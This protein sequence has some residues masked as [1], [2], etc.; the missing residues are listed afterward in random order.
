MKQESIGRIEKIL[1]IGSGV[2]SFAESVKPF[3]FKV[4]GL[5][6][7]DYGVKKCKS[8]GIDCQKFLLEKGNKLPF[9]ENEISLVVMNQV[10]EHI[11]KET[12]QY[13]IK[14][15]MRVLQPGGVGIIKSPSRYSKIWKTDPHH[16][17]C[18][19]PNELYREVSQYIKSSA[20]IKLY[21]TPLEFW[22]L[23]NYNEEVIDIWHKYNKYPKIKRSSI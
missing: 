20:N 19:K 17:Y 6:G 11:D 22:M 7:S 5:E 1:D 13:Y 3:G 14:E 2:G 10:I 21:R 15:I 8:K 23:R 18:W 4:F 9:R 12:G 16:V